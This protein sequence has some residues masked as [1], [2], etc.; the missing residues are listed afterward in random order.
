M[1]KQQ[2][3]THRHAREGKQKMPNSIKK[4]CIEKGSET[5]TEE[6]SQWANIMLRYESL[7]HVSCR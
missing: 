7:Q 1:S 4:M 6:N 3:E 5:F 2:K